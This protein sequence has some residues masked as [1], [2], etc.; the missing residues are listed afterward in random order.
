MFQPRSNTLGANVPAHPVCRPVP[1]TLYPNGGHLAVFHFVSQH[2]VKRQ[3]DSCSVSQL[4]DTQAPLA[5][6]FP[7]TTVRGAKFKSTNC[8]IAVDS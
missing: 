8:V 1:R 3:C 4:P 5:Q 7:A 2:R 6:V